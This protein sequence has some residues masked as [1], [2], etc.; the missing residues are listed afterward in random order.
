M[1]S[2]DELADR[3]FNYL[4]V[5]KGLS[6]ETVESYNRDLLHYFR[7]LKSHSIQDITK[8]DTAVILKHLMKLRESGLGRKSRAR[9]LVSIR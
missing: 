2:M 4:V 9:H 7:F 8:A 5:E 1:A 3:Y 6:K